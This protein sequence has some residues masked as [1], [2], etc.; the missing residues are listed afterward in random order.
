M[1]RER[2]SRSCVDV[3]CQKNWSPEGA[4]SPEEQLT[5]WVGG[6]SV[7]P[8]S[9]HECCPDL[10]CCEPRPGVRLTP[11]P[12]ETREQYARADQATREKMQMG[13]L[14]D[15]ASAL[16]VKFHIAGAGRG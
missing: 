1:H 15:L 8:N 12:K 5:A 11:W 10:S 13:V 7:C 2:F 16:G 9:Q 14:G 4:P 6:T 3:R